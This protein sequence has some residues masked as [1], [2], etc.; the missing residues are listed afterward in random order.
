[1]I[2]ELSAFGLGCAVTEA[3]GWKG[4][5]FRRGAYIAVL[6]TCAGLH[7]V[8]RTVSRRAQLAIYAPAA[9]DFAC[10]SYEPDAQVGDF[11][12]RTR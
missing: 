9:C 4:A 3:L 8:P 10:E 7:K 2:R 5:T 1:M 11:S 6:V 12:R